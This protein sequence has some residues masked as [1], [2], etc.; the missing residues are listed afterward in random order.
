MATMT[1]GG[2]MRRMLCAILTLLCLAAATQAAV[3]PGAEATDA[4]L[5][6]ARRIGHYTDANPAA[7]GAFSAWTAD[8]LTASDLLLVNSYPDLEPS[9]YVV[10]LEGSPDGSSTWVTLDAATGDWH[11]YGATRAGEDFLAVSRREAAGIV[12]RALGRPCASEELRVV[13]LPNRHLYWHIGT[14]GSAS[15]RELFVNV[16]DPD[17][18]RADAGQAPQGGIATRPPRSETIPRAETHPPSGRYPT[19]YDILNVPH[20]F[21]DTGYNCGPAAVEMQ[22]DYFGPHVNQT[23]IAYV[24]NTVSGIGTYDGDCRRAAHF[25]YVSTAAQDPTLHGYDERAIGYG[26][27]ENW[28]GYAAH[29]PDRYSDLKELV[30][31]DYPIMLLTWFD[32]THGTGHFRIVKGYDDNTD[33]FIVHDPWYAGPYSGPDVH[34][35][36]A[37][38]V[39]DL[40]DYSYYWGLL[41]SPWDVAVTAPTEVDEGEEFTMTASAFYPGPHPYES[42]W[43]ASDRDMTIVL[44]LGFV[45]APGETAT[46]SLP[47]QWS[48]GDDP[49]GHSWQVIAE[50]A[51]VPLQIRVKAQGVVSGNSPSYSSYSDWIGGE[52]H[53]TVSTVM[54]NPVTLIRVDHA[55][56]AH[57]TTIQE[58]LTAAAG[59]DTVLVASGT[60]T[61]PLNRNLDFAGKPVLLLSEEGRSETIIDCEGAARGFNFTSGEGLGTV[62][63]GFT[64]TGGAADGNFG[65]GVVCTNGSSPTFRNCVLSGNSAPFLGGGMYCLD[66][67]SPVLDH[68]VFAGNTSVTGSGLYV[69]TGS[70]AVVTHCTFVA[71]SSI[72][73]ACLDASPTVSNTILAF[74]V[75]GGGISCGG[76]SDPTITHS[77]VFGNAGGDSLCGSYADN[78][79]LD[80]FFCDGEE[81]DFTLHDDSPCLLG[82][83]AWGEDVGALGAG[84]CGP[85]TGIE[86]AGPDE[87]AVRV[88]APNPFRETTTFEL[89]IPHAGEDGTVAVYNLRGQRVRTLIDGAI[90]AGS[91]TLTWRGTDDTGRRV[92]SGVYFMTATVGGESVSRKVVVLR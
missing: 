85:L 17:D 67:S 82:N 60:Y 25:S 24:C 48:T 49:E 74:S 4:A 19:S 69:K 27:A 68:V 75:N 61:G 79:F 38:L 84:D 50:G 70:D 23:D 51:P 26:G 21:Q 62:I 44:P 91:L 71:N 2:I 16:A 1:S 46:K 64:L 3:V 86:A 18:V 72:Q 78:M 80:P 76:S 92:A 8:R 83:N 52:G 90:P 9:H 42:Q 12:S 5:T 41:V 53:A 15:A 55:G 59:G 22:L 33:V 31:S 35:N 37:F 43:P 45:L 63:D 54:E 89:V 56:G 6:L 34:F 36:Q 57:F 77:C 81:D 58:A 87:L 66:G 73:I 32:E 29:Y 40:W 10:V 14:P 39:D 11:A 28:W 30:S 13:A 47:G 65:G 20:Y 7:A 88:A